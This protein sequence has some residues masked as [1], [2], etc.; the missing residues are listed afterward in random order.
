MGLAV[1]AAGQDGEVLQVIAQLVEA[2]G[3]MADEIFQQCSLKRPVSS[4]R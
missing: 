2:A 3:G 4:I 1:T